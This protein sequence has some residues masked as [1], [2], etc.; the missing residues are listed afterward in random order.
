MTTLKRVRKKRTNTFFSIF[1]IDLI[2]ELEKDG[3]TGVAVFS[4]SF[5]SELLVTASEGALTITFSDLAFFSESFF[6][7]SSLCW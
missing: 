5:T 7:V 6:C 3:G 2:S 1:T 4:L